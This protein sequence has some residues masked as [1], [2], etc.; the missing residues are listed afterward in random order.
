MSFLKEVSQ[1][2]VFLTFKASFLKEVSHKS[3][4]LNFKASFLKEVSRWR[5]PE[6]ITDS[7]WAVAPSVGTAAGM[8]TNT[9]TKIAVAARQTPLI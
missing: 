8:S 2:N 1:K 5:S 4:V 6:R 3:F 7:P 9:V